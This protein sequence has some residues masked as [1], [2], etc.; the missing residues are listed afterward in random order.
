MHNTCVSMCQAQKKLFN[1]ATLLIGKHKSS[2]DDLLVALYVFKLSMNAAILCG[3]A[4]R[5]LMKSQIHWTS[6]LLCVII[7]HLGSSTSGSGVAGAV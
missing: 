6:F 7:H 5:D 4:L 3:M 2:L 1:L